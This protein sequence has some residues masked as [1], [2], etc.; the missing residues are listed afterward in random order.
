MVKLEKDDIFVNLIW[1]VQ[2]SQEM[3]LQDSRSLCTDLRIGLLEMQKHLV[4]VLGPFASLIWW[5]WNF[6]WGIRDKHYQFSLQLL[7][8]S[9]HILAEFSK[10]RQSRLNCITGG[11]VGMC[12]SCK[13]AAWMNAG[14]RPCPATELDVSGDTPAASASGAIAA[15]ACNNVARFCIPCVGFG[16]WGM[17]G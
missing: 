1:W 12:C 7:G 2:A 10:F 14:G 6:L 8:V 17:H 13:S 5:D 3:L 15:L 11:W 9:L 16:A 4:L